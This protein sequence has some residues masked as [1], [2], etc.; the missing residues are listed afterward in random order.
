MDH[1]IRRVL[2]LQL[3]LLLVASLMAFA[4]WGPGM[5]K[6]VWFG[7]GIATA[8]TLMIAWRMR[9]GR[10][11]APAQAGLSEFYRS[12][13][14]RYLLVGVLLAVG[15]GGLKWPPLGLLSGFVLGQIVWILAPFTFA[16]SRNVKKSKHV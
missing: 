14:E 1:Q 5:A 9:Q 3:A 7:T 10:K 15:L 4:I 12:W 2:G 16:G 6:A 13:L 11:T 8:N